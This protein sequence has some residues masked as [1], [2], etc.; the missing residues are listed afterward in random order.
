MISDFFDLLIEL[1]LWI[2]RK[3]YEMF[4]DIVAYFINLLPSEGFDVQGA[5]N[6]WPSDLAYFLGVFE[7]DY[8]ITVMFTALI[9]RFILRRIPVIG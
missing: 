9:A 1:L 5:I 3:I 8:G 7:V 6:G 4:V 2:P